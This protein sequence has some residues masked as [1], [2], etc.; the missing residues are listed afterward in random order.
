[1]LFS[2]DIWQFCLTDKI[3]SNIYQT[4]WALVLVV[5]ELS[6]GRHLFGT[7][8]LKHLWQESG[9]HGSAVDGLCAYW[10]SDA[11]YLEFDFMSGQF[12]NN[13]LGYKSDPV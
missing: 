8:N 5:I 4:T 13:D 12:Q 1:M 9:K 7:D 2:C 6:Y 3:V 10:L 11:Q